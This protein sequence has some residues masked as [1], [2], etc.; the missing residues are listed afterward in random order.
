MKSRLIKDDTTRKLKRESCG[1]RELNYIKRSKRD[2]R[3][4]EEL[5]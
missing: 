4:R 1:E 5:K 3:E 2:E